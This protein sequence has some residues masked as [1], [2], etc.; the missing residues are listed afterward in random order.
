M[1]PPIYRPVVS[2]EEINNAPDDVLRATLVALCNNDNALRDRVTA[3]FR[4]AANAATKKRKAKDRDAA[5]DQELP[6]SRR[7]KLEG[8]RV[9]VMCEGAYLESENH[10]KACWHHPDEA[11]MDPESYAWDDFP[12]EFMERDTEE[13]RKQWPHGFMY[14][15]CENDLET[16]GCRWGKH[17]ASNKDR[18]LDPER[19]DEGSDKVSDEEV[20]DE[21]VS[22]DEVSD[23]EGSDDD[24]SDGEGSDDEVPNEVVEISSD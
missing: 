14:M 23:D 2:D 21:E 17:Y 11:E 9:C 1:A 4:V 24:G 19:Y 8:L 12:D 13:H 16:P 3:V 15:C 7:R 10:S 22:D 6:Q 18:D 20:S 5:D